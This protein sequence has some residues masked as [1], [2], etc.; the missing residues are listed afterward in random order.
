MSWLSKMHTYKTSRKQVRANNILE[1]MGKGRLH[2]FKIIV[3]GDFIF[4]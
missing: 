3:L 2:E 1:I 4:S